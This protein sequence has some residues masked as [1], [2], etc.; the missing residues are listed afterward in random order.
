[1]KVLTVEKR[2]CTCCMEKH[3]V[4]T[5]LIEEKAIFRGKTVSY[6]ASYLYCDYEDELYVNESL[7]RENREHM[8]DVYKN[9]G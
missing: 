1:M 3:D 5:V 9:I 4:K 6:T 7:M 2:L 8:K